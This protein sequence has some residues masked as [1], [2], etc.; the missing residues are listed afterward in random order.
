VRDP[1]QAGIALHANGEDGCRLSLNVRIPHLLPSK[2]AIP[3]EKHAC[4]NRQKNDPPV[5]GGYRPEDQGNDD[6]VIAMKPFANALG[7]TAAKLKSKR[8][9][10]QFLPLTQSRPY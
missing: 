8:Q 1:K 4:I 10:P 5:N 7:S 2:A 3:G 6:I 9:T